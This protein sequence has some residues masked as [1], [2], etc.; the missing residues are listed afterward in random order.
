[1]RRLFISFL[2]T[3]N[4]LLCNYEI[5]GFAPV[6]NVRFV[7]EACITRWC[8]QWTADDRIF[9]CITDEAKKKNWL[10]DGHTSSSND[11]SDFQKGLATRLKALP[12]TAQFDPII[13][14]TGKSEEEI[15]K[16]FDQVFSLLEE[17]DELYLDIT[18]AFRSLPVLAM[19]ILSYA[20]VMRNISVRAISYGAMEVLGAIA[21][22]KKMPQEERNIP[23]FDLLSFDRLQDWVTA[24]DQ[25]TTSGDATLVERLTDMDMRPIIKETKGQKVDAKTIQ[26]LG[27]QLKEFSAVLATCR[28]R[29]ISTSVTSVRQSFQRIQDLDILPP[30]KPVLQKL[31]PVLDSFPGEEIA[32]GLAAVDWCLN[33]QLYQQGYT[34]LL[35]TMIT[36]VVNKALGNDGRN[37][38]DRELVN[39]CNSIIGKNTPESEWRHP[40]CHDKPITRRMI[41]WMKPQS[42]L[43][44]GIGELNSIRNDLNHAGQNDNPGKAKKIQE[45]LS[46]HLDKMKQIVKRSRQKD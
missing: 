6:Q 20:K 19:A 44:K 41:A 8:E 36:F 25:F 33:H 29:N 31:Q 16:I 34:I 40:A 26:K 5:K 21:E 42:D 12:L 2:G 43:L 24:V 14:P 11:K 10:D 4:Y 23:V 30:L 32:D 46:R 1:M 7:Q 13:I 39:Q 45:E 37:R 38:K 35:E 22:V 9:I 17:G 28:G 15:W 3:N 27:Q 18:H